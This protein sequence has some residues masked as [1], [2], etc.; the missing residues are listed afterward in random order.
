MFWSL[1][2]KRPSWK[3]ERLGL[4]EVMW[5]GGNDVLEFDWETAVVDPLTSYGKR[6]NVMSCSGYWQSNHRIR[7]NNYFLFLE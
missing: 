6:A 3:F 4:V 7:F 2:G 1:I 5:K